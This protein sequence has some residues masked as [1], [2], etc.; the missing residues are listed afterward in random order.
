E[1]SISALYMVL[2]EGAVRD[3]PVAD[4]VRSLVDGHIVLSRTLAEKG[5]FPAVNVLESLSR[6]MPE[7]VAPSHMAAARRV[8]RLLARYEEME[9]LMRL[10]EIKPGVDPETDQAIAAHGD[11]MGYLQ[12]PLDEP[13]PFD[14]AQQHLEELALQHA[15]LGSP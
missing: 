4:E 13:V 10:G 15:A 8:R 1:G 11:I 2:A 9:L 14:E 7:I 12:H 5:V 6:L 3:D